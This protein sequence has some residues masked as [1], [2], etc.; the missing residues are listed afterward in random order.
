MSSLNDEY[1]EFREIY[2]NRQFRKYDEEAY[3]YKGDY[4]V[5]RVETDG[6]LTQFY[7][8]DIRNRIE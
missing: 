1:Q 2:P 4:Y 5:L 8:L 3:Y 6:R 7:K